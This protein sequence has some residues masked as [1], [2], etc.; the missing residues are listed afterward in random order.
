[1]EYHDE[2]PRK[3]RVYVY[4]T[5]AFLLASIFPIVYFKIQ[6]WRAILVT[7]SLLAAI[8]AFYG[9][10]LAIKEGVLTETRSK[11]KSRHFTR[12]VYLV[13]LFAIL[14]IWELYDAL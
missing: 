1:M 5:F 7:L 13:I 2:A 11:D 8:I 10:A 9:D 6:F 3:A 14:I 4:I 12:L